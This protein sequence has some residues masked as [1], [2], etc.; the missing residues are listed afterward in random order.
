MKKIIV[1]LLSILSLTPVLYAL[2]AQADKTSHHK[3]ILIVSSFHISHPFCGD[4]SKN[5]INQ[6]EK[7]QPNVIVDYLEFNSQ[8]NRTIDYHL[9]FLPSIE[10][11]KAGKYD[12]VIAILEDA[13][14]ALTNHSHELPQEIPFIVIGAPINSAQLKQLHPNTTGMLTAFDLKGVLELT[15][16][17]L[18][19]T[20][21][22]LLTL[23]PMPAMNALQTEAKSLKS[24]AK[25]SNKLEVIRTANT[26]E[27]LQKASSLPQNSVIIFPPWFTYAKDGF[28]SLE[29]LNKELVATG[30]PVF[31]LTEVLFNHGVIGGLVHS[32]EYLSED[33]L[34]LVEKVLQ[35]PNV[36]N[37]P[38]VNAR[39]QKV[40]DMNMIQEFNIN[41]HY[42]PKDTLK[43]NKENTIW[44]DYPLEVTLTIAS[45]SS[46]LLLL[47]ITQ[48][49]R[50]NAKKNAQKIAESRDLLQSIFDNVPVGIALKDVDDGFRYTAW[51]KKLAQDT[52]MSDILGKTNS[53][54]ASK[55]PQY[56]HILQ[57]DL[58]VIKHNTVLTVVDN[59]VK[60]DGSI[61]TMQIT[62]M[63]LT[64]STGK[65]YLLAL[66]VDI[67]DIVSKQK[68]LEFA[69]EEVKAANKAKSFFIA[70]VSH[71]IRTP[72]NAVIGFV[73]ILKNSNINAN[74][75][76]HYLELIQQN[77]NVLLQMINDV[78]DLSKLETE[79][80]QIILEPIEFKTLVNEVVA[81]FE[82]QIKE[83]NLK[84]IIEIP[85]LPTLE[86]DRLRI[87]QVLFNL[88][89]NAIKFTDVGHIKI[90]AKFN[91]I[92]ANIG[93][94]VF[95]VNDTGLGVNSDDI[96]K[97]A[98]PF[99][100]LA[101]VRGT[102][103]DNNATGLT[104]PITKRLVERMGGEF[105]LNINEDMSNSFIITIFNV[106]VIHNSAL[107]INHDDNSF[108]ETI[109][110]S[111][112]HNLSVLIVDD[113]IMNIKVMTAMCNKLGITK[114]QT[115]NSG[116][117]ALEI[118]ENSSF[119][120][121][122]TDLWMPD[123]NGYQLANNIKNN[124]KHSHSM[125]IAITADV[126][127][128]DNFDLN[129][130]DDLLFKPVTFDKIKSMIKKIFQKY[131][132]GNL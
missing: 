130:F 71:E 48:Y 63:P 128:K 64:L 103:A 96:N 50:H 23:D 6:L 121:I 122:L 86:L 120:M 112:L 107:V 12:I 129:N 25:F 8:R 118:L 78:L 110:D 99:V 113:I 73:E 106:K 126:N 40:V 93:S 33:T 66:L 84:L 37:I 36:A 29:A 52:G 88:I 44:E 60:V 65:K 74:E 14:Q 101:G 75:Q 131:K 100:Q 109:D 70:S 4:I 34:T 79:Q 98:E 102:N 124:P 13:I 56:S 24:T 16:K 119:D 80:M 46:L 72:L 76:Q 117:Q 125:I 19:E 127:A 30:K 92:S 108:N 90:A 67:T 104:L 38:F 28:P 26:H 95:S 116:R 7:T 55:A 61:L 97:L 11:L 45:I 111:C 3:K 91:Q 62:K 10:L 43:L 123:V 41:E 89:G 22:I 18:P 82:T 35:N 54:L 87:R 32:V 9:K 2:E 21:K 58:N 105:S 59:L 15:S 85:E 94:L 83:K 53:Y 31:V 69:M 20:E 39:S 77:S 51:N 68:Q 132:K 17:L 49:F 114:I 115:S 81:I 57:Q 1:Y 47:F 27:M 5:I 42:I